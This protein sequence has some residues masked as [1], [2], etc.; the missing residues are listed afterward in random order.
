[1]KT[2]LTILASLFI[3]LFGWACSEQTTA[4]DTGEQSQLE[5]FSKHFVASTNIGRQYV[6]ETE[7]Y[8]SEN[9]NRT[10]ELVFNAPLQGDISGQ[11]TITITSEVNYFSKSGKQYGEGTIELNSGRLWDVK[12][13][14]YMTQEKC[15]GI[16]TAYDR[17]GN[18][19]MR[20]KY[21]ED[22]GSHV[23][24]QS[25]QLSLKGDIFEK[26]EVQIDP[27]ANGVF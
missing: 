5:L 13:D 26:S 10:V 20:A 9:K 21:A 3:A 19:I 12:L 23:G 22:C 8:P 25:R 14:G 24:D 15:S 1:M 11:F 2:K 6:T 27:G 7:T 4:P 17:N 18:E 16:M